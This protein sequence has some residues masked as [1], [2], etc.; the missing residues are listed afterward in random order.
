MA[1]GDSLQFVMEQVQR[2]VDDLAATANTVRDA[3]QRA[4]GTV[5]RT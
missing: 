4:A 5:P 3:D 1:T 2:I